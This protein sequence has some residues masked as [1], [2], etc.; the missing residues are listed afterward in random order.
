MSRRLFL[1]FTA[2]TIALVSV[3]GGAVNAQG[4]SQNSQGSQTQQNSNSQVNNANG[5]R[6]SPV[7]SEL[8][9]K[10]GDSQIVDVYLQNIT[11]SP[12][13]LKGVINDFVAADDESGQPRVLLNEN[14]SAP[15]NGLK[16]YV[17]AISEVSL[18]P[19]EQ[20]IVK[21]RVAIPANAAGG[22]Y[23]GVVRFLPSGSDSTKNVSLSASVGTLLLVTV[24]GDIKEEA[25]IASFNVN[26]ANGKASNF[27]TNGSQDNDKKGLQAVVRV[28]NSGNI[29]VAPFGKA[30]LK[31][32]GTTLATYELND[33]TP[34]G[35]VLPDS[36]RRFTIDLGDKTA[37]F[38]RYTIEGNFGYGTSGQ[39]IS[40]KTSFFVVPLPYLLVGIGLLLILIA[41]ILIAP[42]WL[43]AH[44]R[45]L[46]RKVRGSRRK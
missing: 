5:L 20:K 45:K 29:Q 33:V 16:G 13:K 41:A 24:P 31:K 21:I 10:P 6:I 3:L 22:G 42:R 40:A 37:S 9:I 17:D 11:N 2:L 25:N 28:R 36:V 43:R 39:L 23:Y 27:F 34:R 35:N 14:D 7:R 44:D 4:S 38:G 12:A 1:P 15:R 18:Q 30:V 8:T 32:G 26:R 46:L 19:Q